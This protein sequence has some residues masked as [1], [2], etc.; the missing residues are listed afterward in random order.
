PSVYADELRS[1]LARLHGVEPENVATGCGSDDVID[2]ALRAFG[3][4][5][6]G[7]AY[8]VPTFGMVPLF[9][10]MN[11]LRP[12]PVRPSGDVQLDADA[13]LRT[14]ARIVYLC[15]PNNPTGTVLDAGVVERICREAA[16]IVL[17][18][19]AYADFA[20]DDVVR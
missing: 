7:V 19:E 13:L 11:T 1:A 18:D 20:D 15:R 8:P 17:I 6:D 5:G 10:R 9:A 12:Q 3:E 16:G 14:R 4:P 2:S